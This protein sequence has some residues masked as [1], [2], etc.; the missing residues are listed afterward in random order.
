MARITQGTFSLLP[1]LTDDQIKKSKLN[2]Q[3]AKDML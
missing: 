3:S 2:I 1:D